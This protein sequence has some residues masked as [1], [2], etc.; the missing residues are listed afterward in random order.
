MQLSPTTKTLLLATG[1]GCGAAFVAYCI[2][3]DW[4]R[5]NSPDYIP[6]LKRKRL[7]EEK[8]R[9]QEEKSR[10]H[11]QVTSQEDVKAFFL[12]EMKKGQDCL[13]DGNT[14]EA[15]KHLANA[16][17][18]YGDPNELLQVLKTNLPAPTFQMLI[19]ELRSTTGP[20]DMPQP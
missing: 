11:Q 20:A 8:Q 7:A 19:N 13:R 3:F 18:V 14:E 15:V 1:A 6:K 4:K 12:S 5:R 9:L 2:Y 17:R 16:I 10:G